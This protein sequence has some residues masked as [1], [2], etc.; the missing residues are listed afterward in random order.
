MRNV[1]EKYRI[2]FIKN[3]RVSW[4]EIWVLKN[5][6]LDVKKGEVLGVIGPNGSGKTTFLK[7]IAGM[8]LPDKGQVNCKGKISTLMQ[9]GAGFNPEFTGRENIAIN[10]GMYGLG[11][12]E[13][14]QQIGKIIEFAD[15]G[16]FIDAPIKYYSQGM[17]MRLAFFLA[18]FVDPDILLIDDILAVGDADAHEKCI[19]KVFELKQKHKTI[20]LV[21]HDMNMVNKLCDRVIL[22]D[23]GSI[24]HKGR[25]NE[26]ISYYMETIGGAKSIAVLEKGKMRL[27]FNNGKISLR[28]NGYSVSKDPGWYTTFFMDAIDSWIPSFELFWQIRNFQNDTII[29]EGRSYN[30]FLSQSWMLQLD[31]KGLKW[32][33][34]TDDSAQKIRAE[35]FFVPE[36]EKWSTLD[37][38]GNFP[39]F[40]YKSIWQDLGIDDCPRGFLALSSESKSHI[41]PSVAIER[42]NRK[43]NLGVFNTGREQEGRVVRYDLDLNSDNHIFIRIFPE[44][45]EF[46]DYFSNTKR[47]NEQIINDEAKYLQ[48]Q[49]TISKG[50]LRLFADSDRKSIKLFY[51]DIEVTTNTGFHTSFLI[52][53]GWHDNNSSEWQ[54]TKQENSLLLRFFWKRFR[55]T[56]NWEF[57]LNDETVIWQVNGKL[58]DPSIFTIFKIGLCAHQEYKTFFSGHQQQHFPQEFT[59]WQDM[60]LQHNTAECIGLRKTGVFPSLA[61]ENKN[62]LFCIIQNS[63][64]GTRC[65]TLQLSIPQRALGSKEFF[66]STRLDLF[67]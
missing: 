56:Q 65:R 37:K 60:P 30:G 58:E 53:K 57:T 38:T 61:L 20:V 50:N 55:L 7:L 33:V 64:A 28:C 14:H 59:F 5:I 49:R 27:V 1:S 45:D 13:L 22:L 39:G 18:I 23:N 41:F 48:V 3:S 25:P 19:K 2:K 52:D 16:K 43:A 21:S 10:A 35:L 46:K 47:K 6:N 29:V 44:K 62:K 24:V 4:E 31:D 8:L 42:N 11:E 51:K 66:L 54:I 26:V 32:R 15:L 36:Y 9:L 63:D 34:R 67:G 17:H 40:I 12:E